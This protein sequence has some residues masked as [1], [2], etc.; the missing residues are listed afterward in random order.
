MYSDNLVGMVL[1]RT[2][3]KFWRKKEP[4]EW[5]RSIKRIAGC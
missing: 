1:A 3:M 2:G 4:A 5:L